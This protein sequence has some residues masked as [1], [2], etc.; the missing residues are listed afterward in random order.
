MGMQSKTIQQIINTAEKTVTHT[1]NS[2]KSITNN[3][4]M[5]KYIKPV[6]RNSNP[7]LKYIPPKYSPTQTLNN[8][9]NPIYSNSNV[10][11]IKDIVPNNRYSIPPLINKPVYRGN[12]KELIYKDGEWL[13]KSPDDSEN[14]IFK[15]KSNNISSDS[16]ISFG[17][18]PSGYQ[19]NF[20]EALDKS[21]LGMKDIILTE[22]KDAKMKVSKRK[23]SSY[24]PPNDLIKI[25][26]T[27]PVSVLAHELFHR[28]DLK[29]AS[30]KKDR[31]SNEYNF[32]GAL[33]NDYNNLIKKVGGVQNIHK[34]IFK[35]YPQAFTNILGIK[36]KNLVKFDYSSISDILK[37]ASAGKIELGYGHKIDKKALYHYPK[38][39]WAGF[40]KIY[41]ND[42]AEAKKMFKEL[43]P[44]FD[45]VAK[46]ALN[47]IISGFEKRNQ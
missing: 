27:R 22:L 47:N 33:N 3:V 37:Y 21:D 10:S 25:D 32:I 16:I 18:L 23:G 17:D 9:S 31:I 39:G 14:K 8:T 15:I 12:V 13:L 35:N 26:L 38:E 29:Y 30:A 1:L 28:I 7:D 43:F 6:T 42:N 19:K 36:I 11:N 45:V 2:N 20:Y 46:N 5:P 24:N 34:Y 41:F 40:G 44:Q 4:Q